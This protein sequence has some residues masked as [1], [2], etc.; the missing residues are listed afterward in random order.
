VHE[1]VME[2]LDHNIRYLIIRDQEKAPALGAA[3]MAMDSLK[4]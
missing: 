3:R 4:K 1:R 2:G